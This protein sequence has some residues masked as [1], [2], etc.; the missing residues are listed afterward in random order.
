MDGKV[1]E[2]CDQNMIVYEAAI[3]WFDCGGTSMNQIIID[4]KNEDLSVYKILLFGTTDTSATSSCSITVVETTPITLETSIHQTFH[5]VE[6][7]YTIYPDDGSCVVGMYSDE[8]GTLI[9]ASEEQ[10][11]GVA[12]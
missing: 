6:V 12:D 11:F 9:D 1:L 8:I 10:Y 7:L 5:Q 2:A 4:S 3:N